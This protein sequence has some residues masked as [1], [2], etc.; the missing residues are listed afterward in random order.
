MIGAWD[1]FLKKSINAALAAQ[2]INL[3]QDTCGTVLLIFLVM[4]LVCLGVGSWDDAFL[5]FL[6]LLAFFPLA[7]LFLPVFLLA[8]PFLGAIL[9]RIGLIGRIGTIWL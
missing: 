7:T 8:S 1:S 4:N 5:A 6:V 3:L 9:G 2:Y